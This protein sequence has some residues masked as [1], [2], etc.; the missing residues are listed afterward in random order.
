MYIC[1]VENPGKYCREYQTI[2]RS[3][4]KAAQEVGRFQ[5][6]E[7]ITVL[8]SYGKEISRAIYTP[9]DG[10]KYIRVSLGLVNENV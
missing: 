9:E 3:A 8:T 2:T 1:R 4:Y 6:G 7:T 10:G 5:A